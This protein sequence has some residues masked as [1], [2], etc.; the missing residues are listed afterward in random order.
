MKVVVL[1]RECEPN[2]WK[3][4]EGNERVQL[5][6]WC[7]IEVDGIPIPFQASVQE[8]LQPGPAEI[9]PRSFGVVSGRLQLTRVEV[10]QVAPKA[11]ASAASAAK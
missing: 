2:V 11:P 5:R 9:S 8:P 1:N 3:D 7:T 4:K 10:V 6:Q